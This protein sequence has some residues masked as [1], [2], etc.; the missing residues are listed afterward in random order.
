MVMMEKLCNVFTEWQA[1]L[2]PQS[3]MSDLGQH[4]SLKPNTFQYSGYSIYGNDV[5]QNNKLCV[6]KGT[7]IAG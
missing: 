5:N 1:E 4:Y 2:T 3:E 6:N 7:D